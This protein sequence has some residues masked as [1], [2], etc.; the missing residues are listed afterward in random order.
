MEVPRLGV[1][2]ELQLL[3][4]TTAHCNARSLTHWAR[5]GIKPESSWILVG[6]VICW[7]MTGTPEKTICC[8]NFF[9]LFIYQM[10]STDSLLNTLLKRKE[11]EFLLWLSGLRTQYCLFEDVSSIPGLTQWVKDLV[12]AEG[13]D[14]GLQLQL[15]ST[16][17]PGTSVCQVCP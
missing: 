8:L 1:E 5:P 11:L 7:T 2:S 10:I 6:F 12:F 17:S 9:L 15:W 3:A 13:C 14:V 4:Y 16:P